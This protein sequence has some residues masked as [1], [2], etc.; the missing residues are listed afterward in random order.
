MA[1]NKKAIL[2]VIGILGMTFGSCALAHSAP[3]LTA[4]LGYVKL[5]TL[6]RGSDTINHIRLKA[7]KDTAT[8]LGARGALAWR[9]LQ[10]D[11]S[12]KQ[13]ASYLDQVF[14]FNKLLIDNDVLPPV[15]TQDDN[16]LRLD[17]DDT[18]RL[19]SKTYKIV[20]P[21]RFVTVAPTWR[22]YLWMSYD[23]PSMP[24]R[25]LLPIT[26]TEAAVW[27]LYLKKGWKEGLRQANDIFRV[28][29]DRLKRDYDGI[30]LYRQL[31]AQ[32]M[33]SAPYVAKANLGIT[34]NA[35][36]M[37]INDRILRITANS[38]LQTN[39]SKWNPV[40]TQP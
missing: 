5:S 18:I 19:A 21:A 26:Q 16:S 9:S 6:P 31:L 4:D 40:I 37:S 10:I 3:T 17:N 27:N 8:T 39:A 22:T 2:G 34:G 20:S 30:V 24:N 23:K 14:D 15:I 38:K 28:N 33:V 29:L 7:I 25:T 36:Q 1:K 12:L 13:E 11:N 32:K 35:N